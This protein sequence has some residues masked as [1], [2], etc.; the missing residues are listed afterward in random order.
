MPRH[1]DASCR[2]S[3]HQASTLLLL[4]DDYYDYDYY[5]YDY[6]CILLLLVLVLV[7]AG[8]GATN[9]NATATAT[10]YCCRRRRRRIAGLQAVELDTDAQGIALF[11]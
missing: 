1:R 5:D 6:D 10:T 9:I 3:R 7:G 11:R 8:A 4:Y 2:Y